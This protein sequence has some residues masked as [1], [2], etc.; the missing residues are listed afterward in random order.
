MNN[1]FDSSLYGDNKMTEE[2]IDLKNI[3]LGKL[4][5]KRVLAIYAY[6]ATAKDAIENVERLLGECGINGN[7]NEFFTKE[8]FLSNF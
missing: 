8:A 4:D 5:S 2:K 3:N 1:E 6:L 7:T